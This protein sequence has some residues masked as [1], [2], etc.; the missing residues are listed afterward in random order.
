MHRRTS[1]HSSQAA[2]HSR[3]LGVIALE[4]ILVLPVLFIATLACFE[5]A[6]IGL[7][8]Q[9][10]STAVIEGTREGA[11]AYSAALPFDNNPP[12]YGDPTSSDDIADKIALAMDQ[13]LALHGI[14]I[15]MTGINDDTTRANAFIR[16][17][18][19]VSTTE[20]GD[21]SLSAVTTRAGTAPSATEIVVTLAFPLVDASDTQGLGNPVGDWLAPYGLSV[22]SYRF[23][24]SSR[25]PLE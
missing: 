5:F 24:M 7:V 2:S 10:G 13:Y 16:I 23:E 18:R 9:A 8:I 12:A 1:P 17:E 14:E 15:R 25:A 6:F 21:L 11:K 4:F 22:A 3:R 19:G 20:R